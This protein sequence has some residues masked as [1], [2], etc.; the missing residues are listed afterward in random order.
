M[1]LGQSESYKFLDEGTILIGNNA[2]HSSFNALLMDRNT[3]VVPISHAFINGDYTV[4]AGKRLYINNIG[5]TGWSLTIN[6]IDMFIF[7]AIF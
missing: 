4:P 2:I 3:D 1:E 5:L 7:V 6:G